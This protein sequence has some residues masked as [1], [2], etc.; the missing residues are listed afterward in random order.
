[1]APWSAAR[2]RDRAASR[3]GAGARWLV[4]DNVPPHRVTQGDVIV[5]GEGRRVVGYFHVESMDPVVRG[6][7]LS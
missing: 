5:V 7:A 1:M 3:S 6:T 4:G 2:L